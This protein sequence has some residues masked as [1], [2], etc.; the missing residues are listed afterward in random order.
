MTPKQEQWYKKQNEFEAER[1]LDIIY[2]F[3][4]L[5]LNFAMK[6]AILNQSAAED[7]AFT[8]FSE[9]SSLV[10][11]EI[12]KRYEYLTHKRYK[13]LQTKPKASSFWMKDKKNG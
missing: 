13:F 6:R 9:F 8:K 2:L 7:S 11:R 4:R 3:E 12:I 1:L 10:Q 5:N